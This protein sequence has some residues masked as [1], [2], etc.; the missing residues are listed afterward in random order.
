MTSGLWNTGR[1]LGAITLVTV[2]GGAAGSAHADQFHYNNVLVGTR[3]VG[4][5]GAFGAVADDASGVYY[6]PAGLAFAL[7]NDIQGSA[8]AFYRKEA[9]YENVICDE[10][11]VEESSGGLTPFF[12]G[13]QKLDR[14][15]SGLVFAFGVYYTDGDLKDQDTL[16]EDTKICGSGGTTSDLKRYHRTANARSGTYYAGAALGYRPIPNL[17]IGFGLN[18]Y[19]SDELVQEYQDVVFPVVNG[20]LYQVQTINNREHLV[21]HGVQPV[22]GAQLMLPGSVSL[23]L[24]LKQGF[25]AS[26]KFDW[27]KESRVHLYRVEDQGTVSGANPAKDGVAALSKQEYVHDIKEDKPLGGQPMEARLAM[28]WFATPTFLWAF[29]AAYYGAVDKGNKIG[30]LERYKKESVINYATGIEWYASPSFPVRA[31]IFTND[32]AREE[33]KKG[34][35][36]SGEHI[37]YIGESLFIAWVQPNSQISGGFILQQGDGKAQKTGQPDVVQ[38]VKATSYTFAFSATHNL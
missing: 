9:K 16:L 22:L 7:S 21:V 11:F 31:G 8:N 32:D 18:Y 13:L 27:R 10:P 6:N 5:G 15:V 36:S 29:D 3:A 20:T 12:G 2:L 17:S 30:G 34:E 19:N 33:V 28:A 4:M 14:Y 1:T 24:T 37:D 38:D 25:N 23:G 35:L 26:E